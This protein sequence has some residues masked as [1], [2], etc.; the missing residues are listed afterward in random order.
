MLNFDVQGAL[1][2]NPFT[3]F[4]QLCV[5]FV[6]FYFVVKFLWKPAQNIMAKRSAKMQASLDDADKAREEAL[7]Q[8][9]EAKAEL[10]KAY[11]SSSEIVNGAKQEATQLKE[12]ILAEAK[13]ESQA[14]REEVE[15]LIDLHKREVE[16]QL[17]DEI[18]NV[19]MAATAKLLNEKATSKDDNEAIE[20]FVG[21][22][23]KKS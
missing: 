7:Q 22:L 2:P 3:M 10:S 11:E 4:I 13:R 8:L 20:K 9:T 19:A 17:H 1:F 16:S 5:T 15:R 14:R 18:V 12:Q 23:E 21:E 6:L